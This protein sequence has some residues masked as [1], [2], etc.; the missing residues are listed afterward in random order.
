MPRYPRSIRTHSFDNPQ[1]TWPIVDVRDITPSSTSDIQPGSTRAINLSALDTVTVVMSVED[2]AAASA[3]LGAGNARFTATAKAEG[4][5]GNA[6]RV[7]VTSSASAAAGLTAAFAAN[8]LT[9]TLRTG[10]AVTAAAAVQIFN[11]VFG[12]PALLGDAEQIA[13]ARAAIELSLPSN[14]DGSGDLAAVA[15][16]ALS[17]GGVLRQQRIPL[18]P[19]VWHPLS[20]RRLIGTV[21]RTTVVRGAFD[22]PDSRGDA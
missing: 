14:S 1:P 3:T 15:S 11:G 13:A 4:A 22:P 21:S 9:L 6:L 16:T 5:G 12:A 7:V 17:G 20:I 2:E 8:V 19:N 10:T 18:A